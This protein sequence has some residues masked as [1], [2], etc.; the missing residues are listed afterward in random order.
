MSL[1]CSSQHTSGTFHLL[2]EGGADPPRHMEPQ[3]RVSAGR[4][5]AEAIFPVGPVNTSH[6]GT[7]RCYGSYSSYPHVWSHP[8]DPLRLEVTGEG[9]DPVQAH[10]FPGPKMTD[11]S[12]CPVDPWGQGVSDTGLW[13]TEPQAGGL[14]RDTRELS[15]QPQ[16]AMGCVPPGATSPSPQV[17][18]GSPPSR[19]SRAHWCCLETT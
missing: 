10:L 14:G 9:T 5:Y 15:L 17:C 18:T 2:K 16:W 3:W 6:G 4:T 1:S 12:F 13:G 11:P 19:P 8:S 7:Y